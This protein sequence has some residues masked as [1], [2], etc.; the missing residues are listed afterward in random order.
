MTVERQRDRAGR[1][2]EAMQNSSTPLLLSNDDVEATMRREAVARVDTSATA[3]ELHALRAF[4]L[5]KRD[6]YRAR[7]CA[8][9]DDGQTGATARVD[10]PL[11]L[12]P[13][14]VAAALWRLVAAGTPSGDAL[15]ALAGGDALLYELAA[16]VSSPGCPPQAIHADSLFTRDP[17]IVT[18]FLA[19]QDVDE[20]MGPT[21]CLPKTHTRAAH[22]AWIAADD[23][24]WAAA[25]AALAPRSAP[26]RAGEALLLD[27]RA[28]HCGGANV[29]D[30]TRALFYA[31]FILPGARATVGDREPTCLPTL[32]GAH[33]L[34][35]LRRR[36]DPARAR[37]PPAPA[38][39]PS[40]AFLALARA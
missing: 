35:G 28:L 15:G 20:A 32:D 26:L 12:G 22:D 9:W 38:A 39:A 16:L 8:A 18:C 10:M 36:T 19:L 14:C 13:P 6:G 2:N 17:A 24:T 29:S 5:R 27:S 11:P 7:D 3:A 37:P 1:E 21:R 34:A 33:T 4:V 40:A 30:R 25:V 31:S 23:D